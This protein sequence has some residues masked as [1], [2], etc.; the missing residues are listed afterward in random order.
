M[1]VLYI[2]GLDSKPNS[3]KLDL[4]K[5]KGHQVTALHLD[6]RKELNAY[7]L[8]SEHARKSKIE[9]IIGSSLGGYFG[10]WLGHDL[11]V[12]QLLF[13]PAMPYRSVKVQSNNISEKPNVF[14]HV[15]LGAHDDIIPPNLNMSFFSTRDNIKLLTCH[16][17]GHEVDIK[18]FEEMVNWA[19]L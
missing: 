13:N 3:Q 4:I 2:H 8:L 14:S 5:K 17:L 19:G 12:N 15:V 18:T 11:R 16:W 1:N 6:Y 10:Y 7:S 9:Y